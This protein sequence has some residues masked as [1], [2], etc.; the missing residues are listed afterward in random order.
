MHESVLMYPYINKTTEGCYIC[1]NT[2]QLHSD[3]QVVYS[4]NVFVEFKYFKRL[5]RVASP[6]FVFI[7]VIFFTSKMASD[8]EIVAILSCGVRQRY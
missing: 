2:K 8:T 7:T 6:L 3:F 5:A 1:N 4:T